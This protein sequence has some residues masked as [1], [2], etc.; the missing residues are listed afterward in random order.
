MKRYL[1]TGAAGFIGTNL[2]KELCQDGN[3]VHGIDS[4]HPYYSET[5]KKENIESLRDLQNFKFNK[6]DIREIK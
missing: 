1:V 3:E 2:V 4:F 6:W 5:L